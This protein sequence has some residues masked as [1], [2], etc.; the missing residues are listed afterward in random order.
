[1]DHMPMRNTSIRLPDDLLAQLQ[2]RREV[3]VVG[4][5]EKIRLPLNTVILRLLKSAM[6]AK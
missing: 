2:A 1:M 4:S 3:E 6:A 5:G